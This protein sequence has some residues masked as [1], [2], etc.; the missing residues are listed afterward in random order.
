MRNRTSKIQWQ[1]G[2]VH[3]LM[4]IMWLK[5]PQQLINRPWAENVVD[6]FRTGLRFKTRWRTRGRWFLWHCGHSLNYRSHDTQKDFFSVH[7]H[8]ERTGCKTITIFSEH[9]KHSEITLWFDKAIVEY[10]TQFLSYT[11][12]SDP[13]RWVCWGKVW[14]RI[15]NMC[16]YSKKKK[17]KCLWKRE[18]LAKEL[19]TE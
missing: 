11:H 12:G 6:P 10:T 8:S 16:E 7:N 18:K 9:R 1:L 3:L 14:V 4:T 17:N 19:D 13:G 5:A 15:R 2:K